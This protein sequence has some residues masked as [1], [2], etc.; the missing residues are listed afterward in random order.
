VD[1][2]V[3][4]ITDFNFS[5]PVKALRTGDN[6]MTKAMAE[7]LNQKEYPVISYAFVSAEI[8]DAYNAIL[9]GNMTIAGVTKQIATPVAISTTLEEMTISGSKPML[10]TDF[11][12]QPPKIIL[13]LYK[14][15][16]EITIHYFIHLEKVYK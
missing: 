16:N 1:G 4:E 3:T 8:V 14:A 2:K 9:I 7:A 15:K 12:I 5:F 13:G 6:T 10:M 11:G